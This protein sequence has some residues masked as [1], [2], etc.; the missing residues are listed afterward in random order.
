MEQYFEQI[1]S[2]MEVAYN[3]V[4]GGN[5][6]RSPALTYRSK[7]FAATNEGMVNNT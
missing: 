3:G 7:V 1:L 4:G 6:M 5:M 2:H